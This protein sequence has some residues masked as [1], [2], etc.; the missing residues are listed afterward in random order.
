MWGCRPAAVGL[1]AGVGSKLA[2][3]WRRA[4]Q[5]LAFLV[6]ISAGCVKLCTASLNMETADSFRA[7]PACLPACLGSSCSPSSHAGQLGCVCV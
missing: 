3:S 7:T 6:Q 2:S 1:V 4:S 5:T